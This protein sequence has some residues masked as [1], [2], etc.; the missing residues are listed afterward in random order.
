VSCRGDNGVD[1]GPA[2]IPSLAQI[3]LTYAKSLVSI[4]KRNGSAS[5]SFSFIFVAANSTCVEGPSTENFQTFLSLD[6]SNPPIFA[7]L[8]ILIMGFKYV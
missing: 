4:L 8:N 6:G 7:H 5:W 2:V 1:F 3:L